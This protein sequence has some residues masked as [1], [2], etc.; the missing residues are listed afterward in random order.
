[1]N[2]LKAQAG[3]MSEAT[4]FSFST[5]DA[6]KTTNRADKADN[7]KRRFIAIELSVHLKLKEKTKAKGR[8]LTPSD[9]VEYFPKHNTRANGNIQGMFGS[10]HGNFQH[11]I[12]GVDDLLLHSTHFIPK[13]QGKAFILTWLKFIKLH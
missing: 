5:K 4:D 2:P 9:F 1:L 8:C 3:Q 7:K 13:N 12:T 6:E 11:L 10:F